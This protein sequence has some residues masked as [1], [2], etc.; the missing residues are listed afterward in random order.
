MPELYDVLGEGVSS[1]YTVD[2]TE[3]SGIP[4]PNIV[5]SA[6]S[7]ELYTTSSSSGQTQGFCMDD[8]GNIYGIYYKGGKFVRYNVN[9]GVATIFSTF[10]SGTEVYG[11]ANGMTYNPN[12]GYIYIAPMLATG[13]VY[14]IDPSD[15]TFADTLYAYKADGETPVNVWN[16]CY[17]REN[18]QFI[19]MSSGT[20]YFYD[21][22]FE[23]ISIATYD[24]NDWVL[25]R[26]DIETDGTY[27]YASSTEDNAVYVFKMDGTLVGTIT[28]DDQT[29]ELED[30]VY[31]WQTGLFFSCYSKRNQTY[32]GA[33]ID[34]LDMKAY[35]TNAEVEA[36]LSL[37]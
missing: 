29:N 33:K 3:I 23:L 4:S 24:I 14:V 20:I 25:T 32:T 6:V 28:L 8:E 15:M 37:A 36:I 12:T 1:V 10:T 22:T 34:F 19:C 18:S 35:Y 13:E 26:Q 17:D 16:I 7:H 11:H 30:V 9:T 31:D 27:I 5:D 21:D 2:G